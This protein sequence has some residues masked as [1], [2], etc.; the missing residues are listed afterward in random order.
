MTCLCVISA[1]ADCFAMVSNATMGN[2]A[3]WVR[4]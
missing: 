4:C 3:V 1:T 2:A